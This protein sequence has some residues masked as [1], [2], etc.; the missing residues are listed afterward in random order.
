MHKITDVK[1]QRCIGGVWQ[2]V[3]RPLDLSE[4][5]IALA[6]AIS[7]D[8]N[9]FSQHSHSGGFGLPW[10]MMPIPMPPAPPYPEEGVAGPEGAAGGDPGTSPGGG[11]T[12]APASCSLSFLLRFVVTPLAR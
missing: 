2:V 3:A 1:V 12:G 11:E 9:Y 6:A 7:I 4:R 8:F 5:M 10:L